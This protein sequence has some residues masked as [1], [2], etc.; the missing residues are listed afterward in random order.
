MEFPIG[1]DDTV[2]RATPQPTQR[3]RDGRSIRTMELAFTSRSSAR[4][5]GRTSLHIVTI[6]EMARKLL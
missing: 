2:G 4:S 1:A 3:G 5:N 6:R